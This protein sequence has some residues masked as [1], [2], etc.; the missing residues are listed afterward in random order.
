MVL[1]VK[2]PDISAFMGYLLTYTSI[3]KN[4]I[5]LG[6]VAH[7]YNPRTREAEQ[8]GLCESQASLVAIGS[9][10]LSWAVQRGS[11]VKKKKKD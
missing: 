2:C 3:F 7:A 6:T 4:M 5:E 9:S 11:C 8:A 1:H 10:R